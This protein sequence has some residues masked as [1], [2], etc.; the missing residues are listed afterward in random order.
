MTKGD[1]NGSKQACHELWCE[2]HNDHG[3]KTSKCRLFQG[4]VGCLL[5][6]G[7]L[8]EHFGEKEKLSY[9]K[10]RNKEEPQK[11]STPKR[12][13]NVIF[14]GEEVNIV[15]FIVTHKFTKMSISHKKQMREIIVVFDNKDVDGLNMP[16]TD[17]LV[18]TL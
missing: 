7:Y 3:H 4:E 9:M 11:V 17:A 6:Q 1:V 16:H 10:N 8:T 13:V 5:R 18:I 15:T 12:I 2:F 14:G